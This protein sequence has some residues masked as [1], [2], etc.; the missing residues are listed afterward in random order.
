MIN[1]KVLSFLFFV[2]CQ[3]NLLAQQNVYHAHASKVDF[4]SE[5][6]LE[7]IKASSTQLKGLLD[8]Q[9][10]TFAFSIPIESFKG[11]NSPLQREHFNENYMEARIYPMAQFQGKIIEQIDFAKDGEYIIRAKGPFE[12][13]GVEQERIIKLKLKVAKGVLIANASFTVLLSEHNIS[14]PKVVYQ[15]IEEE[16]K[17]NV[18]VEFI[19]NSK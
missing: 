7:Q 8:P 16:I 11:F 13:H 12:I 3:F 5:A 6:P 15:K 17:V 1:N 2:A 10:R 4:I 19:K 9:K 18:Y 14:V